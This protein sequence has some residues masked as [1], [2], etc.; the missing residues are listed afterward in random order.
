MKSDTA[1]TAL[2]VAGV[3]LAAYVAWRL[4]RA[5]GVVVD[6]VADAYKPGGAAYEAGN[7]VQDALVP[8]VGTVGT[9]LYDVFNSAPDLSGP[10]FPVV[11]GTVFSVNGDGSNLRAYNWTSR[12]FQNTSGIKLPANW[13]NAPRVLPRFAELKSAGQPWYKPWDGTNMGLNAALQR[14]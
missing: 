3:A 14:A 1:K 9:W 4:S 10:L 2:I 8:G 5:A 7:A 11:A 6:T 13:K 12:S